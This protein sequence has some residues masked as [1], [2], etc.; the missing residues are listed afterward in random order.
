[1]SRPLRVVA[2]D[3]SLAATGIAVTHDQVGEPR[4]ACRTITPRARGNRRTMIDH[5]RMSETIGAIQAAMNC[6]PDVT[7][8]EEPLLIAG[9]GDTSVRLGELH[10]AIKH[11]IWARG[12]PYVDVHPSHVKQFATGN[13]GA[14]KEKVR[15]AIIASYGQLLHVHTYDEA[16]AVSMLAMARCAYG[17]PLRDRDGLDIQPPAAAAKA[18]SKTSWPELAVTL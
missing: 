13:G 5:A 17:Q 6:R 3:L 16:D 12:Y 10:G 18:I 2:L 15:A 8:I 4:L 1:M 11:W 9:K 7:V 14:D